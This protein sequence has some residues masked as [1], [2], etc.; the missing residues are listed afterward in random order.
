[1]VSRISLRIPECYDRPPPGRSGP[2]TLFALPCLDSARGLSLVGDVLA[3]A[4]GIKP[5]EEPRDPAKL[6]EDLK[7]AR[8]EAQAEIAR[9]DEQLR[10]KTPELAVL[11]VAAR[12]KIDGGP[13]RDSRSFLATLNSLDPASPDFAGW[14][15]RSLRQPERSPSTS[16]R[17]HPSRQGHSW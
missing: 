17:R 10:A 11:Q 5:S 9:R 2:E 7:S 6:T 3:V 12:N 16:W 15:R 8:A 13:L 14:T 4:L 1:M